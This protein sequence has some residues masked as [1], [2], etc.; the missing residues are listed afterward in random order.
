[1]IRASLN[2]Q[3]YFSAYSTTENAGYELFT[4]APGDASQTPKLLDLRPGAAG[5][6]INGLTAGPDALYAV[7]YGRPLEDLSR[8]FSLGGQAVT[9]SLDFVR[10]DTWDSEELRLYLDGQLVFSQPF[11]YYGNND[12]RTGSSEGYGWSITPISAL[13]QFGGSV[14]WQ[15]QIFRVSVTIPAGHASIRLGLGTTLDEALDNESYGI[16]N[17]EIRPVANPGQLLLSD[18]GADPSLWRGGRTASSTALGTFLGVYGGANEWNLWRLDPTE[19]N[20]TMRPLLPA[21][22]PNKESVRNLF[23][24]GGT[25]YFSYDDG[26]NGRELWQSDG[27][28]AGTRLAA[29]INGRSLPASPQLLTDV[30]GKL[31]FTADNGVNGRG[32]YV[33]NSATGQVQRLVVPGLSGGNTYYIDSLVNANGRLYF[34]TSY[35]NDAGTYRPLYTLDPGT[36]A[37]SQVAGLQ[38]VDGISYLGGQLF[39]RAYS[40]SFQEGYE[41][42][43]IADGSAQPVLID[44][45]P[46]GGSSSA[47]ELVEAGGVLYFTAERAG[48][49]RELFRLDASF[50]AVPVRDIWPG[51]NGANP[52]SL[53][54]VGSSLYFVA[55]DGFHGA[56][57][58]QTDG[59]EAGTRLARDINNLT[60]DASP[61]GLL[62]VNGI[63]YFIATDGGLGRGL[64]RIDPAS[65]TP[66]RI[67]VPGLT[68]G[69]EAYIDGLVNAN[70]RLYFRSSYYSNS[71]VYRPLYTLDPATEVIS[72]V[73]G[74]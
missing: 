73:S 25:L 42:F 68:G 61:D 71:S 65:G 16:R 40:S 46:G 26:V 5:T 69:N 11:V 37:I 45:N 28:A 23:T 49:G 13:D 12:L 6:S 70:G 9:L 53:F 43:R 62:D 35:F 54:A 72:Q 27:T 52:R 14:S 44:V 57:L 51:A 66:Q 63:L 74:V 31:Y 48:I 17:L 18:S 19:L 50:N 56:E 36:G 21:S 32:L 4:L 8:T 67:T 34:R 24:V 38:Y 58:W 55:D 33:L 39:F 2:G 60:L 20:R 47:Q 1:L 30:N 10:L 29:D 59:T 41:L 3:A 7:T 64:Y 22:A 15:D